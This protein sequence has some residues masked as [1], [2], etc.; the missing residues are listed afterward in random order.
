MATSVD[1]YFQNVGPLGANPHRGRPTSDG[2]TEFETSFLD[3]LNSPSISSFYKVKLD[4]ANTNS[5]GTLEKHLQR[6]GV[7][8]ATSGAADQERFSLLASEAMLP[9]STLATSSETG[10][11]QGIVERFAGQRTF[12]DVAVTYYLTGDYRSLTLF[13]EWINYIN[14][15]YIDNKKP[16]E[17]SYVGYPQQRHFESNN[18]LRYRY[19]AQY[20]RT[21]SITKFERNIAKNTTSADAVSYKFINIFPTSIQDIALSYAASQLLQVT[22]QFAYDRYVLVRNSE[23]LGTQQESF[24]SNEKKNNNEQLLENTDNNSKKAVVTGA[25]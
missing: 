17:A 6:S 23:N 7:Y 18:F 4:L 8:D 1:S 5:D 9:G 24:P 13:Q 21:M 22:V 25:E 11:R 20:K 3:S 12:N 19:P 14:P 15:M 16:E 10:S 2:G